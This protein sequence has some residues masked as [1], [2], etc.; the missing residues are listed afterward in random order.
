MK[1]ILGAL[2]MQIPQTLVDY[3]QLDPVW[4]YIALLA[5]GLA[6]VPHF[7]LDHLGLNRISDHQLKFFQMNA[8]LRSSDAFLKAKRGVHVP[9]SPRNGLCF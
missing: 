5:S 6:L 4:M 2:S 7:S 1:S 8:F 3:I 9:V